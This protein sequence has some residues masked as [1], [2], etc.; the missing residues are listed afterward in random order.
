MNVVSFYAPRPEHPLFQ[1]YNPFLKLLDA[2]CEKY[3]HKHIVL[4]DDASAIKDCA[5]YETPLP[6]SLMKATITAQ[7]AY[8]SDPLFINAPTLLTG[9][10]CVLANDPMAAMGNFDLG[11]TLG[12]FTDCRMNC[13]AIFIPCPSDVAHIWA[14]ALDRCG[15]AWGDDQ[16]SLYDEILK[17]RRSSGLL[18]KE[19]PVDPYNLAPEHPGD[20]CT[21]GV[22]LHFRGPRKAWMATYCHKW[23]GIGEGFKA[24]ALPNIDDETVFRNVGINSRRDLPWI[25]ET[26]PHD[27]HAVLVGGGPSLAE[28]LDEI[29]YRQDRGQTVF[30]LNGVARYL[31]AQHICADYGVVLDARAEN[32]R[33]VTDEMPWLLASQ[34]DPAVFDAAGQ[35]ATLWHFNTPGITDYMPPNKLDTPL[36]GGG[37]TVGLTAMAL[38]FT[39]GYR[40]IHL[41]GYDSSDRASEGHAYEQTETSDEQKRVT[42]WCAGK[43]FICPVTMYAQA[44]KFEAWARL[45]ADQGAIITV[46]G[47]GL[48]PTLAHAMAGSIPVTEEQDA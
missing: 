14:H 45:L 4:T 12:D 2:S 41:F 39:M 44:E 30:A 46:H 13:G 22:V 7:L 21:R 27:G 9:A 42:V 8:L 37:W 32:A 5:A 20:D 48:L 40:K 10:D 24:I 34:C 23:L 3:G 47:D 35:D 38:V 36:V 6:R 15:D 1:D 11:I 29:A 25:K 26:A 17:A 16:T 18:V 31:A 33:F 19:Y 43:S 28:T